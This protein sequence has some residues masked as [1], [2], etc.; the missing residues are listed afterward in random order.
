[1]REEATHTQGYAMIAM[2]GVVMLISTW[3]L[4]AAIK[5]ERFAEL[6]GF[7]ALLGMA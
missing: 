7:S 4:Y 2:A 6:F 1:M 5:S 3:M